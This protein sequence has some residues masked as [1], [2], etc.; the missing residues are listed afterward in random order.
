[1]NYVEHIDADY[2]EKLN[3]N[4]MKK[5]LHEEHEDMALIRRMPL[6]RYKGCFLHSYRNGQMVHLEYVQLLVH[7]IDRIDLIILQNHFESP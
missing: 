6:A 2:E 5:R 1:M 3:Y 4:L 7:Q